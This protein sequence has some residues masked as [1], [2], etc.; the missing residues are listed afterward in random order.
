[1]NKAL[2]FNIQAEVQGSL[3]KPIVYCCC[4]FPYS[5]SGVQL[6]AV[7]WTA[8]HQASLSFLSPRVCSNS[9]PSSQWCYPTILFSVIPFSSCP[10]SFPASGS[11][12][13]SLF[14][15]SGGQSI[16]ASALASVLPMNI[17]NWFPL[18]WTGLISFLSK[19]LSK[20]SSSAPQF[21]S[22]NCLAF[23][24]FMAQQSYPYMTT[25]KTIALTIWTFVGKVI[26][27]HCNRCPG[28]S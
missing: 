16:G 23:S 6:F 5:L 26:S 25:G 2:W 20:E 17:Q 10:Q 15:P 7:P 8:A 11:F 3:R 9:C 4:S 24:L 27:L 1:M 14:F 12:P 13:V 18:G 19:E 21:E 22:I 28:W